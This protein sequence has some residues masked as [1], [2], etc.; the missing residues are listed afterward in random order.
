[1][2]LLAGFCAALII[3]SV[4]ARE[5]RTAAFQARYFAGL[6]R[7]L[8]FRMAPGPSP[9]IRFPTAGPYD[10][11][12]GY[13]Q[14]PD[15]LDRLMA[16][17][18]MFQS[19][20]RLSPHLQRIIDRGI[21]P[22]YGEKTQAGLRILDRHSERVFAVRYPQRVYATFEEIPELIVQ[23]LLFIENR[24]L[25]DPRYRRRNPAVEWDRL[26]RAFVD[27][28][29]RSV[30][31][32]HH[33]AGG[34]TL[35]TQLE[36]FR[37]SPEGRTTSPVEKL[38][39]MV[40]ASIRAYRYGEETLASQRQI[41]LD[42]I[43]SIPL[44]ALPGYGEVYGLGDGLWAWYNADFEHVNH[45]LTHVGRDTDVAG[46]AERALA[47]KQVLSLF[48]AHRLPSFYLRRNPSALNALTDNYL[49][50]VSEAGLIL[51]A[52]RDAALQV[53]PPVQQMALAKTRVSFLERKAANMI[54]TDLL[55]LLDV[56]G[57]YDLDRLDLT[58]ES[59]LDLPTQ[60]AVTKT[61]QQWRDPATVAAAG[62]RG[63]RL[64]DKHAD[65]AKVRYSLVLY[66][67]GPQANLLRVHTDN[68]DKPFDSNSGLKL[69]L[70][71]TAK[72]RTLVTYL[73]IVATLHSR[74]AS[75]P[76]SVRRAIQV[77]QSDRLTRW[78][79]DYL[80]N[81][82]DTSLLGMLD[83][84]MNRP[85]SA[86]PAERFFTGGGL[87]TFVNFKPEDNDRVLSVREAFRR[88]VN[89][90]FIRLMRDIVHYYM[91]RV[92]GSTD[93]LLEDRHHPQRQA[94]LSRFADREGRIFI[95]RFF[96]KYSGKSPE[97]I[98]DS[99]LDGV[100]PTPQRLATLYGVLE[101]HAS[102]E[103]FTAFVHTHLPQQQLSEQAIR[104]LYTRYVTAAFTLADSGYL[105]RIHPLELWVTAYLR[106]HPHASRQ[107]VM[108]ASTEVRQHVY[109]W[110]FKT[111]RKHAQDR[112]IRTLLE[113]E[114]FFEIHQAWQRL[115]Y[116]FASLVP[117]YATAIGSSADRPDALAEL[118]GIIVN[119]G[120][121][122]SHRHI[123]TLHFA[124]GTPYETVMEPAPIAAQVLQPE[125][126]AVVKQA[127]LDVV[128]QGTARRVHG[129]F[130]RPDGS[131]MS[132]GGK[133]GT[134]DHQHKRYGA[135]GRL[136]ESQ[137][138]NR[139]AVFV[140]MIDDR[141]FG[142]LTTYVPG[143]EA[144]DYSFTSSLPVQALKTLAS[145]LQPMLQGEGHKTA[146][147]Q[148]LSEKRG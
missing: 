114:A 69:D 52:L 95:Q 9:S 108:A 8:T 140:F 91:F 27:V 46:L 101:P 34:S 147:E 94:Y 105:T 112:R 120:M 44:A 121:R 141:F 1:M 131:V 53:R 58:V 133:T 128:E 64:L 124:A 37:H 67:R 87:H 7:Q 36:K 32:D 82:A 13:T 77:H 83:A 47:Y 88:S 127:L 50:L 59:T 75:L 107:D 137:A 51:P 90:V 23:T 98:L 11:R 39:Q 62:F 99:L 142:T 104:K 135:G 54:R 79:L 60:T 28:S 14:L 113:A 16:D 126:A 139:T 103:A 24:E 49:H 5:L 6:A 55:T 45:L 102:V 41:V 93:K 111:R 4:V 80:A 48:V 10:E 122:Y 81:A 143:S 43:N 72:L 56:P 15:F 106:R 119:E 146:L 57:L 18:Y 2:L 97:A 92:P 66:E 134:G 21:F 68:L 117:S 85:Y 89:L 132:V 63:K 109:R 31:K 12:L 130:R 74:Y 148:T 29:I 125:V 84:A 33:L 136:L 30:K 145:T 115:G 118:I 110:L 40:T 70:G 22:I 71:S 144:A 20:A 73:E 78:A 123:Q 100:R 19:Q 65:P 76:R 3:G 61:F 42:Y 38:R 116:P 26:I 138:V 129:A 25:L 35:A 17:T 86:S 96:R